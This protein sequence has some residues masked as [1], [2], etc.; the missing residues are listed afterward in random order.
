M[1]EKTYPNS[2]AMFG[3]NKTS[4]KAADMGGD[5]TLEDDV[6]DYILLCVERRRPIKLEIAGWKRRTRDG[7]QM[8]SLKIQTPYEERGGAPQR[9]QSRGNDRGGGGQ[10]RQSYGHR[11]DGPA[12]IRRERP[13]EDYQGGRDRP[14]HRDMRRDMEDEIPFG[15]EPRGRDSGMDKWDR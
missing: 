12:E 2:G 9:Q 3:R 4:D 14:G 15:G 5:F 1:A 11:D 6:L 8:L 7:G 10:Q 13:R